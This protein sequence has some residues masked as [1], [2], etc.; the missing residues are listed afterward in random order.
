MPVMPI[1]NCL[2][3][4]PR[5][6]RAQFFANRALG[7]VHALTSFEQITRQQNSGK[8]IAGQHLTPEQRVAGIDSMIRRAFQVR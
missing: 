7:H 1:A 2:N 5:A 6:P 4:S 8:N 3:S